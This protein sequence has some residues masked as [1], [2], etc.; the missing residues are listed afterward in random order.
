MI[1]SIDIFCTVIDN[2][3][4]IGVCWRL[5]KQLHHEYDLQVRLWVDDLHSFSQFERVV[6]VSHAQQTVNG[7]D[8]YR[9]SIQDD[10]STILPADVVIEGFG[11]RLPDAYLDHMAHAHPAPVWL[12]LEYLS[13][14]HWVSDCHG[15]LSIH[16]RLGL[17][18]YFFFPSFLAQSGGLLRESELLNQRLRFCQSQQT[19][20]LFWQSIG[21]AD[22]PSFRTKMSL[23]AYENPAIIG[24]LTAL[25]Q[26]DSPSLVVIPQNRALHCV[27]AFLGK[28]LRVGDVVNCGQLRICVIDLLSPSQYDHLLWACDLNI[29]RGEDSFVRAH[30]AGKPLLWDIY[31]QADLAHLHK[32]SAW[33]ACAAPFI[34]A[35]W[36]Q[37]QSYWVNQQN[38]PDYWQSLTPQL[39]S[40][41]V[42]H[43][44]FCQFLAQQ[45]SLCQQLVTFC[46]K[47][48]DAI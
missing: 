11:C 29:V 42:E 27:N 30:W 2:L 34:D 18:Q 22:A 13:A 4:D 1:N 35:S 36:Q 5:A 26:Q 12:N 37:L 6:S 25:S 10:F 48:H 31:P 21:C 23:F 45:D 17:K 20:A 9:W 8:I 28:S 44:A 32:L 3:G 16:P 24:L 38:S 39:A 19:Q 46:T 33:L 14:E 41:Q 7:I 40:R 43:E 15:M 47:K